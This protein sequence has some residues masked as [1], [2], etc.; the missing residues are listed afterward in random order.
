LVESEIWKQGVY[1]RAWVQGEEK[2][3]VLADFGNPHSRK[4]SFSFEK[5][6]VKLV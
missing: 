4:Y 5:Q 6:N 3:E 1:T 2:N